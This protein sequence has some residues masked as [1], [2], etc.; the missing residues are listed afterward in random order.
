MGQ[1]LDVYGRVGTALFEHDVYFQSVGRNAAWMAGLARAKA[2]IEY[3]RALRYELRLLSRCD[4]V[5][6]CTGQNRD[7][8][9]EFEPR[10]AARVQAGLR[11]CI[12]T[13]RYAFPGGPRQ[14]NTL[15]FIGSSRHDPNRIAIEWFI[16]KV[17][18]AI[19]SA[20][21]QARLYLAGF[22]K[23]SNPDLAVSSQIEMLG[24]VEDVRPLL[25]TC[26]VFICPILSGSGVRV[27]LLEA[28]SG[29]IPVVSTRI[30]AEG[31]AEVDGELCALADR[32]EDFARRTIE[33]LE[34]PS[35]AEQM[36]YRARTEMEQHWDS[37]QVTARLVASYREVLKGKAAG[38]PKSF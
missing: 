22:T 11:A 7:Y 24:S 26:S 21:P 35:S 31:L 29:G 17:F 5:Q 3:V 2:R 38:T 12:D 1:Y 18:P 20:C 23:E 10:L 34:N 32:P 25:D 13:Q 33:L 36:A 19:V 16:G 28:F 27:K 14:P 15:L 6:V 8:L 4:Q 37:A 9:L 30:G